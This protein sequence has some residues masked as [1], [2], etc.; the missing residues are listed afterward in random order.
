MTA[1]PV[2]CFVL[3]TLLLG[4]AAQAQPADPATP[5]A[6]SSKAPTGTPASLVVLFDTGS[7]DLNTQAAA[8][9][10]RAA[11]AYG[12][13]KPLVMILTGASDRVG[14]ARRNLTLS[15]R[16]TTAVLNGLLDRGIPADRFQL[17]AK[18]ETELA[19]PTAVGVPEARN[20]SVEITW[21]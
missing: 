10:D 15:Q 17:L 16:R 9:L 3:A 8:V 13:G 20:R 4:G 18:G 1:S 7:S 2:T 6:A 19:I 12:E 21:R 11:R 14:N 5:E